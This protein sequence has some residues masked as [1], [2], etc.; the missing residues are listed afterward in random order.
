[1]LEAAFMEGVRLM[2]VARH[3]TERLAGAGHE[4]PDLIAGHAEP[5]RA[6]ADMGDDLVDDQSLLLRRTRVQSTRNWH[7]KLAREWGV[8]SFSREIGVSSREIG[9][10][11]FS[12]GRKGDILVYL[13]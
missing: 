12:R 5:H 9:V 3:L 6:D 13:T 11:S 4:A 7:A 2:R 8:S 10:S 1:D